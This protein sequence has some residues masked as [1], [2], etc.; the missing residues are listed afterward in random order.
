[1]S[2]ETYTENHKFLPFKNAFNLKTIQL[3]SNKNN[4]LMYFFSAY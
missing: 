1:M 2:S 4:A 3:F